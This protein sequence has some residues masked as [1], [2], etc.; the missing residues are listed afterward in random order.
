MAVELAD[1]VNLL[2][3]EYLFQGL[4]QAQLTWLAARFEAREYPRDTTLF[5]EGSPGDSFFT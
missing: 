5:L 3:R 2:Q 1:K 4:T